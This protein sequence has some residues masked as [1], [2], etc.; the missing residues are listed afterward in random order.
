M[1]KTRIETKLRASF[2][3]TYLSVTDESHLHIGHANYRP[4]G[5][6][7]FKVLIISSLFCGMSRIKRHQQVYA[8]LSEELKEIVHALQLKTLC[9]GEEAS[10]EAG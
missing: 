6:S 8:C 3:P 2:S 5:N 10:H 4:G 9:P 7:H 1:I